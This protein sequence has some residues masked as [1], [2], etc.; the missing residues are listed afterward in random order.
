MNLKSKDLFQA[1]ESLFIKC[2]LFIYIW[3]ISFLDRF[4]SWP[5][6]LIA[7]FCLVRKNLALYYTT[8]KLC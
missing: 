3:L 2:F 1:K 8:I 6:I 7:L 4:C 5:L